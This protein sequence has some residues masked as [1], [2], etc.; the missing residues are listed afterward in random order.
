MER[1][2]ADRRLMSGINGS[3]L[4]RESKPDSKQ[5]SISV[6]MDGSS[7]HYRVHYEQGCYFISKDFTFPDVATLVEYYSDKTADGLISNLS[8]QIPKAAL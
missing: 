8:Y 3:F 5:Y 1:G 2:D 4:I 7:Y 6:K